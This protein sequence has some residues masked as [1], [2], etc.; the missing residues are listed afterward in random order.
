M[1]SKTPSQY[2]PQGRQHRTFFIVLIWEA[3]LPFVRL[4]RTTSPK[5]HV[6]ILEGCLI[7]T[8]SPLCLGL[9]WVY[10]HIFPSIP[11]WSC[12]WIF[13]LKIYSFLEEKLKKKKSAWRI[14]F[15]LPKNTFFFGIFPSKTH[16]FFSLHSR[17][18]GTPAITRAHYV[19]GRC[20]RI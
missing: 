11:L 4:K 18:I 3:C 15:F 1:K 13:D 16:L 9:K 19:P 10:D 14:F 17:V 7:N 5:N 2:S 12:F 20:Y 8:G 6:A